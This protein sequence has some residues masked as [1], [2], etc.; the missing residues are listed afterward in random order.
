MTKATTRLL[1][2]DLAPPSEALRDLASLIGPLADLRIETAPPGTTGSGLAGDL[3]HRV[4]R[5]GAA[6]LILALPRRHGDE[7]RLAEALDHL[8]VPAFALVPDAGAREIFE[9]LRLGFS[10]FFCVPLSKSSVL[11]RLWR[12]IEHLRPDPAGG[13]PVSIRSLERSV[14]LRRL[15]GRNPAFLRERDKIPLIAGCDAGVLITGETGTGKEVTARA[16][17]YLSPRARGPFVPIN[18]G[19]VPVDLAENELF[20]HERG[21]F[22]GADAARAGLIEEADGGSLLLDE[23]D[24]LPPA[25]QVKLLRFLQDG[26]LRRL[27]G[28]RPKTCDVRVIAATNT[29]VAQAVASGRL[30][31][32]LYYRLNVIPLTLPPL[33]DRRDDVPLLARHFLRAY[34]AEL[35]RPPGELSDGAMASLLAH[36]WPGNVRELQHAVQRAMVLAGG[37]RVLERG[38]FQFLSGTESSELSFREAKARMVARFERSFVEDLLATHRGNIS[39]AARAARKNRRAFFELIR[40]HGIDAERFRPT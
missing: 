8:S 20:G 39:R 18:C 36:E 13:R 4:E 27:G 33:R 37:R 38:D 31:S 14:G 16:I 2:L 6:A 21:A 22:T 26:E 9:L 17:H 19:A 3:Q 1:L 11:P 30:R 10:D 12:S 28:T 5:W 24:S 7:A 35:G 32:D 34:A 23:V 25:A 40:K 15:L 29:D